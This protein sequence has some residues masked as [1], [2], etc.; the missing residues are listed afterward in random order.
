MTR[1]GIT[2]VKAKM[3]MPKLSTRKTILKTNCPVNPRPDGR[4]TEK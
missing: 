3:L 2:I 1:N 4:I